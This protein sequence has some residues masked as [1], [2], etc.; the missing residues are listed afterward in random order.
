MKEWKFSIYDKLL[1]TKNVIFCKFPKISRHSWVAVIHF[2]FLFSWNVRLWPYLTKHAAVIY[3]L[4][5]FFRRDNINTYKITKNNCT[6][7]RWNGLGSQ[8]LLLVVWSH[9]VPLLLSG[10][11]RSMSHLCHPLDS[12]CIRIHRVL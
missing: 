9:P 10:R 3:A 8:L 12:G 7:C 5:P 6:N 11:D 2:T 4:F 1:H